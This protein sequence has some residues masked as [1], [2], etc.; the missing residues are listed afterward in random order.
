[1]KTGAT[2]VM[3]LS[4]ATGATATT[5]PVRAEGRAPIINENLPD[6]RDEAIVDAKKKA[7][8]QEVGAHLESRTFVQNGELITQEIE[9]RVDAYVPNYAVEREWRQEGALHVAIVA[10]VVTGAQMENQILAIARKVNNVAVAVK[11]TNIGAPS[12]SSSVASALIDGLVA[13][14][15]RILDPELLQALGQERPGIFGPQG[16]SSPEETRQAAARYLVNVVVAGTAESTD[17]TADLSDYNV[18]KEKMIP[19]A[20]ARALLKVILAD[21]GEVMCAKEVSLPRGKFSPSGSRIEDAGR[22]AL[23]AVGQ[24]AA[25]AILEGNCIPGKLREILVEVE[26]IATYDAY[27]Q[28]AALLKAVRYSKSVREEGYRR[29]GRSAFRVMYEEDVRFLASRIEGDPH[30]RV[31]EQSAG[32]ILATYE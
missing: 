28:F 32:R 23:K 29:Q 30:Y 10:N 14:G 2:L 20:R 15:Y 22:E 3:L 19:S 17:S 13:A 6:A 25:R 16:S 18:P 26:G 7:A 8:E 9:E 5:K 27:Q 24:D 4:L 21:T 12:P 11:E 1:M 31:Q